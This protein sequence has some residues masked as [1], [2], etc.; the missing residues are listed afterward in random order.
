MNLT[1]LCTMRQ[2]LPQ[3]SPCSNIFQLQSLNKKYTIRY[4]RCETIYQI[5]SAIK[6]TNKKSLFQLIRSKHDWDPMN[7]S[8]SIVRLNYNHLSGDIYRNKVK[9]LSLSK[10][11]LHFKSSSCIVY[12]C[13]TATLNNLNLACKYCTYW[14]NLYQFFNHSKNNTSDCPFWESY[15][16]RYQFLV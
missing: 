7:P 2:K 14:L 3:F 16:N 10:H 11:K 5:I 13:M 9:S 1:N 4:A 8:F 15:H 6:I 12:C